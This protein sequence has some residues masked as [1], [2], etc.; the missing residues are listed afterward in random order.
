M[1]VGRR[2]MFVGR[3]TMGESKYLPCSRWKVDASRPH[4]EETSCVST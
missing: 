4:F 3:R 1:F 2:S